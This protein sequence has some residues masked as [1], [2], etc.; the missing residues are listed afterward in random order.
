MPFSLP[1]I[2]KAVERLL[3]E[4]E[5][6]VADFPRKRRST[7]EKL[8][9]QASLVTELVHRVWR[10]R[11]IALLPLLSYISTYAGPIPSHDAAT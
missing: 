2:T 6:A 7:G 4:I 3:L 9:A 11:A 10:D 5:K 8:S 1:P